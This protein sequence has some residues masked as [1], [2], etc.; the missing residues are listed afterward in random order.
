MVEV[1]TVVEKPAALAPMGAVVHGIAVCVLAD[2]PAAREPGQIDAEAS[3]NGYV[4][5]DDV[6]PCGRV[7]ATAA[8]VDDCGD[9]CGE[10]YCFLETFGGPKWPAGID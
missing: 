8:A 10:Y 1:V 4:D 2:Y 5:S 9:Y 3:A 7:A 6:G